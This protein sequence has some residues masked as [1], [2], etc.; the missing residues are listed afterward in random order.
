MMSDA[1]GISF[2]SH[3]IPREE[4]FGEYHFVTPGN[5]AAMALL[6][7]DKSVLTGMV[8]QWVLN[9]MVIT[10]SQFVVALTLASTPHSMD[11][12]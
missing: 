9:P 12:K 3:P 8:A 5:A 10:G 1:F 6:N 4:R 2:P 11:S 7:P